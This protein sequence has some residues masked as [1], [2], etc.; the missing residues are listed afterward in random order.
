[1]D[2]V[3]TEFGSHQPQLVRR[4][5]W[6]ENRGTR[7]NHALG[8]AAGGRSFARTQQCCYVFIEVT[9]H[10]GVGVIPENNP[11]GVGI[12]LHLDGDA[13]R[14]H[15][16]A[17]GGCDRRE[18]GVDVHPRLHGEHL[19]V[20]LHRCVGNCSEDLSPSWA[21]ERVGGGAHAVLIY[22]DTPTTSG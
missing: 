21:V 19:A 7:L 1:M 14:R 22:T 17:D 6:H 16:S 4:D 20:K 18:D 12:A 10:R 11:R 13:R 2:V 9:N 15:V 3:L 5:F 8:Q